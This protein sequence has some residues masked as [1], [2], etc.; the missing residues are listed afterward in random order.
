MVGRVPDSDGCYRVTIPWE[1]VTEIG[2]ITIVGTA[3]EGWIYNIAGRLT[4]TKLR[5]RPGTVAATTLRE[6]LEAV[7]A[8]DTRVEHWRSELVTALTEADQALQERHDLV[9][10]THYAVYDGKEWVPRRRRTRLEPLSVA[11]ARGVQVDPEKLRADDLGKPL[12][13]IEVRRVRK[14]LEAVEARLG[15]AYANLVSGFPDPV[16]GGTTQL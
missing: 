15:R 14:R 10:S 1:V 9:H 7:T 8:P 5:D 16:D 12:D 3:I 2:C 4:L 6:E 13:L 11:L